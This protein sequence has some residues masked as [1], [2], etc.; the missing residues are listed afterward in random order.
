MQA[1]EIGV[2]ILVYPIAAPPTGNPVNLIGATVTLRSQ[3][4]SMAGARP[5]ISNFSMTVSN[6]GTNATYT[7]QAGDFPLAGFYQLELIAVWTSGRTLRSPIQSIQVGPI[8]PGT[9]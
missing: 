5:I 7:T 1:N 3:G 8:I 6:D 4:P 2:V 9:P